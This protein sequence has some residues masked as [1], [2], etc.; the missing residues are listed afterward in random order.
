MTSKR[1]TGWRSSSSSIGRT[2]GKSPIAC[3]DRSPAATRQLARRARRR[4]RGVPVRDEVDIA[5]Q[6]ELIDAFLAASRAGDFDALVNVLDRDVVFCADAGLDSA[7]ARG[8]IEGA[9]A[10]AERI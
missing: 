10:V 8:P 4:I 6:R 3:S 9:E 2:C 1:T 7:R 5:L